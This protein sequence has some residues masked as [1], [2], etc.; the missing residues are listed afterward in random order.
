MKWKHE[1]DFLLCQNKSEW[2]WVSDR[3]IWSHVVSLFTGCQ[4]L[5]IWMFI[6]V[7]TETVWIRSTE[8]KFYT[9]SINTAE[10]SSL[11]LQQSSGFRRLSTKSRD[12]AASKNKLCPC[13][14]IHRQNHHDGSDTENCSSADERRRK[15]LRHWTLREQQHEDWSTVRHEPDHLLLSSAP[16]SL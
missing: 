12:R 1:K 11:L 9:C 14:T 8:G 4:I 2:H 15:E 5:N 16:N 3:L 10:E 6:H 7:L 13:Q